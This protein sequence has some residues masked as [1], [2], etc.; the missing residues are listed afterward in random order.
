MFCVATTSG[1]YCVADRG[2]LSRI[3]IFTHPGSRIP[4]PK[5]ALK[6][7]GEKNLLSNLFFG[8]INLSKLN[9]FIFEMSKKKILVNFQKISI[10]L[11]TQKIVTKF[12]K[13]WFWDPRS[14]I[15]KKP[16]TD[17]GSRG[18]KGTGSRIRI[19]IHFN[20]RKS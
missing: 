11:F 1:A 20:Q 15:R 14:G 5:T 2:C 16:I 17:P 4:D 10:E 12:S 3:L 18:Q 13:I 6:D 9:Y 7:R 8:A 19:H